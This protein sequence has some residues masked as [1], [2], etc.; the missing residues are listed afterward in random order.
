MPNPMPELD[1]R[2]LE[3][4]RFAVESFDSNPLTA[5]RAIAKLLSVGSPTLFRETLAM[6]RS[7]Q[8]SPAHRF[9]MDVLLE[10]DR[11]LAAICDRNQSSIEDAAELIRVLSKSEPLLDVKLLRTL[12]NRIAEDLGDAAAILARELLAVYDAAGLGGRLMPLFIQLLRKQDPLIRSKVALLV[13]R[14]SNQ[15][16]WAVGD[17]DPRVRANAIESMWGVRTNPARTI[18]WKAVRDPH[19]RVVGNALYGLLLIEEPGGEDEV[20]RVARHDSALFRASAAWVIG[21]SKVPGLLATLQELARDPE[22]NVRQAAMR[23][24]TR[25]ETIIP[26]EPA[27]Q[28]ASAPTPT[29]AEETAPPAVAEAPEDPEPPRK[30]PGRRGG[31]Y[32]TIRGLTL[33]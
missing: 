16:G 5:R 30:A 26:P 7:G 6:L 19:Q 8:R 17:P 28:E 13:G 25:F 31:W 2:A 18:L 1:D 12:L 29:P 27:A 20:R 21:Q 11:L 32:T 9:L 3:A 22:E 10:N 4:L 24:L 23:A 14:T 15:I 33:R